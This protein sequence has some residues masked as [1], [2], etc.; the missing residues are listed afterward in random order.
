MQL[1]VELALIGNLGGALVAVMFLYA[2][3]IVAWRRNED[4]YDYGFHAAPIGKGVAI[5]GTAIAVIFPLFVAGYFVFYEIACNSSLLA[6]LVPHG[7]C[8]RYGGL[9]GVHAPA[10]E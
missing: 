2:P 7:M 9:A 4:L 6:H 8:A 10:L 1:N 5:A 3:V